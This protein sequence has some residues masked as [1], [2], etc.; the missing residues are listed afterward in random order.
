MSRMVPALTFLAICSAVAFAEGPQARSMEPRKGKAGAVLVIKGIHLGKT[1]VED[2][3]LTDHRFDMKVKV[4]AQTE[5]ILTVRIPPFA[6]PGRQQLLLLTGG[7]DPKLLEQPVY[8]LVEQEETE[9]ADARKLD[10][11]AAAPRR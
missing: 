9:T 1:A 7:D 10:G 6:K 2:V 8:V 5:E 3:F 11:D 4:L